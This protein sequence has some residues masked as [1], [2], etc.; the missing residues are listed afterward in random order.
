MEFSCG[1]LWDKGSVRGRYRE[2]T[3]NGL[4]VTPYGFRKKLIEEVKGYWGIQTNEETLRQVFGSEDRNLA[5]AREER[6]QAMVPRVEKDAVETQSQNV[7][8]EAGGDEAGNLNSIRADVLTATTDPT[9]T[10]R[11]I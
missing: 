3:N 9:V 6:T 5:A 8:M 1:D 11:W 10:E 2:V 7:G 4:S